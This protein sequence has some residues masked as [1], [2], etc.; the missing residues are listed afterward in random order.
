MNAKI[1]IGTLL[2]HGHFVSGG[3]DRLI[4]MRTL[5]GLS[6]D[7]LLRLLPHSNL[8]DRQVHF[9]AAKFSV[10]CAGKMLPYFE[11][12]HPHDDRARKLLESAKLW[13]NNGTPVSPFALIWC[14][15]WRPVQE[16]HE[17]WSLP[18]NAMQAIIDAAL[19]CGAVD[20][21]TAC[22]KARS[23]LWLSSWRTPTGWAGEDAEYREYLRTL[24]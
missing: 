18:G 5:E 11:Q 21:K 3:L 12:E 20:G 9:I 10:F 24:I 13:L 8:R 22:A 2:K 19:C 7:E 6:A 17:A 1:T 23:A 16:K 14:A 15:K 4:E